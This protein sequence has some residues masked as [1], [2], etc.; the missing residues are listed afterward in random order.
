M[1]DRSSGVGLA[2]SLG[3]VALALAASALFAL[4]ENALAGA[5]RPR[6]H[7]LAQD[8]DERALL[9]KALLDA[10][11]ATF[12]ALTLG[13]TLSLV[14]AATIAAAI[15]IGLSHEYAV[16]TATAALTVFATVLSQA[17]PAAIAARRA[18]DIALALGRA[19]RVVVA[20]LGPAS[21]A[22]RAVAHVLLMPFGA[23]LP[24]ARATPSAEELR[25]A[26]E[27][28]DGPDPEVKQERDM[29]RGVLDLDEVTVAEVMTHRRNVFAVD[30]ADPPRAIVDQVIASGYTHVPL[31]SGQQ[32]NIVGI[33]SA[34]VLMREVMERGRDL[35]GLDMAAI[36]GKPWFVPEST[37]LQDQLQAFRERDDR[38]ALVVDEYGA[39][40]GLVTVNDVVEEVVG[41]IGRAREAA[42]DSVLPGVRQASDG[43]YLIEGTVTL[44]DLNRALEWELPDEHATTIA[45]LVLHEARLIPSVGQAFAFYGFRFEILRRQRHQIMAV[46][47]TPPKQ[48]AA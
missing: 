47:V 24:P 32:E 25:G 18:D 34:A 42:A 23:L 30:I 36:A 1:P 21:R 46:R 7:Q 12:G 22:A 35:V 44:R 2:L 41:K 38:Q 28:H 48:A 37:T 31:T 5:S 26:I 6:V 27:M 45:G 16:A 29:L 15:L 13:N 14:A 33:L 10:R 3:T 17:L 20:V 8:G 43:S 19:I 39:W 40:M 11:E 4:A 9:V